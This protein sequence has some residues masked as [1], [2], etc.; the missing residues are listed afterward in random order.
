MDERVINGQLGLCIGIKAVYMSLNGTD[1]WGGETLGV[2]VQ[3]IVIGH[4]NLKTT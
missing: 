4:I 3:Y 1:I 2:D